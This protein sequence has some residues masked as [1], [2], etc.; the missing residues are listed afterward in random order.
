M[1]SPCDTSVL[2]AAQRICKLFPLPWL[3]PQGLS[4]ILQKAGVM[5]VIRFPSGAEG[6]VYEEW[7]SLTVLRFRD[8]FRSVRM[9]VCVRYVTVCGVYACV[10]VL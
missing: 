7:E 3:S 1:W 6:V 10:C 8:I 4:Y 5:C 2:C 9:C